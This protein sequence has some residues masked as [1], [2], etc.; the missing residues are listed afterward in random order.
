LLPRAPLS[1][2]LP[3]PAAAWLARRGAQHRAQRV[4]ALSPVDGGWDIDGE[5]FDA[6]VL[7]CS[8]TEAARLVAPLAPSWSARAAAFGYE[9][10]VTVVVQAPGLRLPVPMMALQDGPQAPA[11]FVFD[12]GALGGRT[13]RFAFV[14]SGAAAWVARG[15]DATAAAV[16]VQAETAFRG[17]WPASAHVTRT[18]AERRA[19]FR[20]TPTLDRPPQ[21]IAR[22]LRAAGDYLEGPYPAT[23]EGAVRSGEAAITAL[24][25]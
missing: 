6:V 12:H 11:Q 8:A 4:A 18:I 15:L 24:A 17:S 10:I 9:P 21:A 2:L 22:G 3:D 16:C 14:V 5:R 13:G 25:I 7:A 19:T 1:A 23:L 20:C